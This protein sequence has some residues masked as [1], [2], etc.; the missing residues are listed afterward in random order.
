MPVPE[1]EQARYTVADHYDADIYFYAGD[2]QWKADDTFTTNLRSRTRKRKNFLLMINTFG[3][4][5]TAAYRIGRCVQ[6][7][8]K[9]ISEKPGP[10]G[11]ELPPDPNKKRFLLF[12]D[13]Y[14]KSAGT[15]LALGADTVIMSDYAELGPIDVQLRKDDEVGERGSG[16]TPI[17]ALS[18]LRSQSIELF[19]GWFTSLRF[20]PKYG[21]STRIASEV[22]AKVTA[23]LLSPI[24]EQID[25]MK[26]AEMDR[27]LRIAAEYGE[28]LAKSN[29]KDGALTRLLTA[30]P[31][32]AFAIDR[33]EA[34][35][36]FRSVETPSAELEQMG[37]FFRTFSDNI[38]MTD[39]DPVHFWVTEEIPE[40][41]AGQAQEGE[42]PEMATPNRVAVG[43][44]GQ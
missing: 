32:H 44:D 24:Y 22:A 23:G 6:S 18:V 28:R 33:T 36:I 30:Y 15:I 43:G 11:F 16:L 38:I 21:F 10:A 1:I 29:L 17:Q 42:A 40:G 3:G 26:M 4:D 2:L 13:R 19:K 31:S 5:A 8:Y 39:R 12:V 7:C 14:C 41:G 27:S 25:P 20:D 34:S 9:T 37:E 35:D